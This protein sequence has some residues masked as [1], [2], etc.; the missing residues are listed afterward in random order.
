MNLLP[1]V[2]VENASEQCLKVCEI[3]KDRGYVFLSEEPVWIKYWGAI[4]V[5]DLEVWFSSYLPNPNSGVNVYL[6]Y[7]FPIEEKDEAP[8]C[9]YF[10]SLFK[11]GK[12]GFPRE[13]GLLRHLV[14]KTN[15]GVTVIEGVSIEQSMLYE[16]L[17]QA[18][19]LQSEPKLI[20]YGNENAFP[21]LE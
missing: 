13:H 15:D 4:I 12:A 5:C 10:E 20:K 18:T 3:L 9:K 7:R 8:L 21:E 2:W 16:N 1:H 14:E 6:L 11:T 19:T 17:T